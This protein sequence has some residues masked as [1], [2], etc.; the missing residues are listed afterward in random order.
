LL[1]HGAAFLFLLWYVTPLAM[2]EPDV[3]PAHPRT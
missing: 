1:T 3:E 2:F